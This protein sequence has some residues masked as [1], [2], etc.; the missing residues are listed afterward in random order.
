LREIV[1]LREVGGSSKDDFL[2]VIPSRSCLVDIW[3]DDGSGIYR[4]D[5]IVNWRDAH[6]NI[7]TSRPSEEFTFT[8]TYQCL[9]VLRKTQVRYVEVP[10]S[11]RDNGLDEVQ[12]LVS[13]MRSMIGS[14]RG[15]SAMTQDAREKLRGDI[16]DIL[17]ASND[18]LVRLKY[19]AKEDAEW[20]K[21]LNLPSFASEG[22]GSEEQWEE[23]ARDNPWSPEQ[24]ADLFEY[25]IRDFGS[26]ERIEDLVWLMNHVIDI[27]TSLKDFGS[28]DVDW[29]F[30]YD[31]EA[32]INRVLG[33]DEENP[34]TRVAI[35]SFDLDGPILT[36]RQPEARGGHSVREDTLSFGQKSAVTTECWMAWLENED[37]DQMNNED[38][39]R[40][41]ILDE[42]EAGRSEYWIRLLADRIV[43]ADEEIEG[44][45]DK[46]LVVM[47]HREELLR[48]L[49]EGG[50]FHVMQPSDISPALGIEE[51]G[52]EPEEEDDIPVDL[53]ASPEEVIQ[54]G[55]RLP[56]S[57]DLSISKGLPDELAART[58]FLRGS[59]IRSYC[60]SI[61]VSERGSKAQITAR[62]LETLERIFKGREKDMASLEGLHSDSEVQGKGKPKRPTEKK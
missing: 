26:E 59:L 30:L 29:D 44:V 46:S 23:W 36:F 16:G 37:L 58:I 15:S 18:K 42:P 40:C 48:R 35:V 45:R 53:L 39:R 6:E 11:V 32:N 5:K 9:E 52:E 60:R 34:W 50:N 3:K 51:W 10:K 56:G 31:L 25:L 61:G 8:P 20:M 43:D 19:M 22:D 28:G 62:L 7:E 27:R 13:G 14:G 38:I 33:S 21:R 47:S 12:D 49:D 54:L 4:L 41:L 57:E 1:A 2:P 17:H 24:F 55:I